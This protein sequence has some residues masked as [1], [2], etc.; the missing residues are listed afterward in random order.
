MSRLPIL[1]WLA[2]LLNA[3]TLPVSPDLNKLAEATVRRAIEQFGP[4]GLTEDRIALTIIDMNDRKRP[5][6][7]SYRGETA[8]YPASVC[9]LFYL[10][11][12]HA[13]LESGKLKEKTPELDRAIHDMVASSSNDATQLSSICLP[14]RPEARKSR[15]HEMAPWLEKRNA[16]NRYYAGL[17]YQGSTSTRRPSPRTLMGASGRTADRTRRMETG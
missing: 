6:W 1:L 13:W 8:F 5:V 2:S 12:A 14:A 10:N 4:G 16:V 11:A 7:G 3:Q 9:K 17:G 15:P